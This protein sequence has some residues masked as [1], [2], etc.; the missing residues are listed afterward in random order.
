MVICEFLECK[1]GASFGL[2]LKK[3][4]YCSIHKT[5]DMIDVIHKT[6][7]FPGCKTRPNY[8]ISSE[9]IAL[10]CASHKTADM[11][12]VKS[13]TCEFSGCKTQPTYNIPGEKVALYCS[14]HKTADMIDVKNKTCKFS[15]CKTQPTYNIS[16][17]KVAL[18]CSIHKT[19]DMIDVK[20]KT[21]EFPDCKT[22]PT[23]NI[24]GEKVALYCSIHKT[25]DMIDVKSK[26][27]EFPGCKTRPTYNKPG[28]SP[29]FCTQHKTQNMIKNPTKKC[30]IC[31]K[32]QAFY[33]KNKTLTHCEEHKLDNEINLVEK[34]CKSCGLDYLLDDKELCEFCNPLKFTTGRLAKQNALMEYLDI[35]G[36]EGNSTD[37]I[38]N[39]GECGKE[40]PDRIY[41]LSDKI[42]ILECDENQHKD[43][44]CVC[45]Q[46]RMIN[47]SNSFGGTPVYFIRWNPDKY[48]SLIQ[49]PINIRHKVCADIILD[50]I[51][52]RIQL[53]KNLTSVIYLYFDNFNQDDI[54][55]WLKVQ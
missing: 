10:Y 22:R 25:A 54:T 36:L 43:R 55:N 4:I 6:C 34:P 26:T 23:Y 41:D 15:G 31:K 24:S 27:C 32:N 53:P 46:Q 39:F 45:E 47:I 9:K 52:A 18:Y 16:G 38:I 42:I 5:A 50:I 28:Y 11:V 3:P 20:N 12:D 14:I 19:A 30:N 2:I 37:K 21:C 44:Q 49:V 51:N 35:R 48:K 40:R 13:K 7:E 8:N 1:K 29:I 17:K 33:G